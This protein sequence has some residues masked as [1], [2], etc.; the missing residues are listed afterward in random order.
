MKIFSSR[1]SRLL[2]L[3]IF[4][5]ILAAF[6]FLPSENHILPSE[7]VRFEQFTEK[8]FLNEISSNTLN[9]HYTLANPEKYGIKNYKISLGSVSPENHKKNIRSLK[10]LEKKLLTFSPEK[11][12]EE[13]QMLYDILRLE[14]SSQ[15]SAGEEYL[16]SEPLGPNLG[17]QAQLPALLAEYTFRNSRD[18]KDYFSLLSSIPAYFHEIMEFERQKS[19]QGLFMSNDSADRIISQCTAFTE[20]SKDNFLHDMFQQRMDKLLV[21][22]RITRKQYD[23]FLNM[24]TQLMEN[25]VFPAYETLSKDLAGLKGSGKNKIGLAGLP[26]GK[27]YY[28]S[29]IKNS[30]GDYRSIQEIEKELQNKLLQD[31][32]KLQELLKKDPKIPEKA[33]KQSNFPKYS[34]EQMLDYLRRIMTDDF[35][36]LTVSD[37]EVKYVH[38]SMEDFSSPAFYLTPPIDALSPNV[39]YI[40]RKNQI[41]QAELFT[42][43]AH[44]GF[45]GHM[46]QTLYFGNQHAAPLRNLLSC[47]GYIEGWA[48]YTEFHSYQYGAPYLGIE[49]DVMQFLSLNRSVSLCLYSL[50]DIGIHYKGWTPKVV[51]DTLTV[52][53]ITKD[54][55]C[56]DIFQYIAENPSNYLKYYLGY[57]NFSNLEAL[58]RE[59]Q[60]N[61]FSIKDFHRNLLELGPA[62]FP[63]IKKYLLLRYSEEKTKKAYSSN[64]LYAGL[65][66]I[67]GRNQKILLNSAAPSPKLP[68]AP[69][70]NPL[71]LPVSFHHEISCGAHLLHG[72]FL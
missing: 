11:L 2:L 71:K 42:T 51:K 8:L 18:I 13:N 41:S 47:G 38:K 55:V 32:E 30:V 22:K 40:N 44:E 60:G 34:P 48:T 1:K 24:H 39:I 43:L 9:L 15:L 66:F 56:R 23:S 19:E 21:Q 31:Y 45:P 54:D 63:V 10:A 5:L 64:S 28:E 29:L 46:Y 69:R 26:G 12:S 37:Y 7:D 57:L 20:N 3:S 25:Y 61:S 50:L 33:A 17:I 27:A 70:L 4:F 35:P 49:P 36:A 16:L 65:F 68:A 52:F 62:P 14:F 59:L 58:I 6:F 53:G 67:S 72:L